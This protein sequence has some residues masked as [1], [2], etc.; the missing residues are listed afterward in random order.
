[1]LASHP[2]VFPRLRPG[3]HGSLGG[4]ESR[5]YFSHF[6]EEQMSLKGAVG[7]WPLRFLSQSKGPFGLRGVGG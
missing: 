2:G 6:A 3:A 1:M 7:G 5:K 4:K